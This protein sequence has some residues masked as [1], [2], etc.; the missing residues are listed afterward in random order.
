MARLAL[1]PGSFDPFTLGHLDIA[2]RALRLFDAVEI[3]VAANPEKKASMP[4][5]VRAALIQE[6]TADIQN[7]SVRTFEGLVAAYA[8]ARGATA[9]IRGVR[10]ACD[11]TYE[12][13]M[14]MANSRLC[15]EL[16]TIF[17]LT[18]PAYA[19]T[20]SSLVRDIARW[21]G[22]LT[23]FVPPAVAAALRRPYA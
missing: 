20:S 2:Q 1:Y 8:E 13:K 4:A 16:E 19:H 3:I 23:P 17:L 15:A 7:L 21:G 12:A 18:A 5:D 14:A 9:L 10:S 22:D 11:V 6:A